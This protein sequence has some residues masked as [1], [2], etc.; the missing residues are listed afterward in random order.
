MM[1]NVVPDSQV[2]FIVFFCFVVA[3]SEAETFEFNRRVSNV[4][5]NEINTR[6]VAHGRNALRLNKILCQVAQKHAED[7][8]KN[9][10]FSHHSPQNGSLQ[11][12][13]KTT[14]YSYRTIG[15]NLLAGYLSPLSVVNAWMKSAKHRVTILEEAYREIGIGY[16]GV[17]KVSDKRSKGPYWVTVFGASSN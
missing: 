1:K 7:M 16:V 14:S 9:N 13:I 6:R 11:D 17:S 12:R 5:L 4:V 3:P 10:F 15:E 2:L 8:E